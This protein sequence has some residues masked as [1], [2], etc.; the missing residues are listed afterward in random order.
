MTY[1]FRAHDVRDFAIMLNKD[2]R[3][4]TREVAGTPVNIHF[5]VRCTDYVDAIFAEAENSLPLFDELFGEYAW[6]DLDIVL[7]DYGEEFDGGM[8]YP[9]LVTVN[10]PSV[11][12]DPAELAQTVSHEIAH[13]WFYG[14]VGS[15]SYSEPW[16]DESFSQ[17][18]SYEA[19]YG[20]DGFGWIES[21]GKDAP[22]L[23][24]P[25]SEFTDARVYGD[26]VYDYGAKTLSDFR[27]LIGEQ[28]FRE[29]MHTYVDR[30]RFRNATT[31]D[32]LR[33]AEEVTGNDH[34]QFWTGHRIQIK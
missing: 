32:F 24:A 4:E 14:M 18:A 34:K 20:P 1:R 21:P 2:F 7:V 13:Q 9:Q 23:N 27:V 3:T 33:V 11:E 25:A 8:E 5:P 26:I 6:P 22:L 30:F 28:Q 29:V 15:D 19:V 17:F 31:L 12:D 10:M 16:L